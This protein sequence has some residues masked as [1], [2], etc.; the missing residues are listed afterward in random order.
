MGFVSPPATSTACN[1]STRNWR[2]PSPASPADTIWL[3]C[4]FESPEAAVDAFYV[5]Y[6]LECPDEFLAEHIRRIV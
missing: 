2:R 4:S 6:P 1:D 3:L 5:A